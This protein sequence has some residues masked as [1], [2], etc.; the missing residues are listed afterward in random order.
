MN[1]PTTFD[2]VPAI[3]HYLKLENKFLTK[4]A[5]EQKIVMEKIKKK[6]ED[7]KKE[8]ERRELYNKFMEEREKKYKER[9]EQR[10][11]RALNAVESK[12]SE[13]LLHLPSIPK[14]RKKYNIK[15]S[16]RY[17]NTHCSKCHPSRETICYPLHQIPD[18]SICERCLRRLNHIDFHFK[19]M[20]KSIPYEIIQPAPFIESTDDRMNNRVNDIQRSILEAME[21]SKD[22]QNNKNLYSKL[23]R[24]NKFVSNHQ[25]QSRD[26]LRDINLQKKRIT[27]QILLEQQKQ[28]KYN[29]LPI[30]KFSTL[31][32]LNDEELD[33]IAPTIPPPRN[34]TNINQQADHHLP[35]STNSQY[36]TSK[37]YFIPMYSYLQS[38]SNDDIKHNHH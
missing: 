21:K 3:I 22:K 7:R 31:N 20:Y 10:K 37:T 28:E 4:R 30:H 29:S 17:G 32:P 24:L 11:R 33:L 5:N 38:S 36:W 8:L 34:A 26:L 25:Q 13:S 27:N 1:N 9:L 6:E 2:Y 23:G 14:N 35:P 18:G 15:S 19:K 16:A 12:K